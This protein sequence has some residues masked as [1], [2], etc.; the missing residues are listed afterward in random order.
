MSINSLSSK[1]TERIA[2]LDSLNPLS[3]S[4]N[5][6]AG[7]WID[8]RDFHDVLAAAQV[9]VISGGGTF[10]FKIQEANTAAGGSPA[11]ITGKAITQIGQTGSPAVG[12][13]N[14][15]VFI[16]L[17]ADELTEGFRWVRIVITT[18]TAASVCAAQLYGSSPR[19]GPASDYDAGS[20]HDFDDAFA[21]R[22]ISRDLAVQVPV[23]PVIP[24]LQTEPTLPPA[25]VVPAKT[26]TIQ[27][28]LEELEGPAEVKP[29]PYRATL[30]RRSRS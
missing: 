10:N 28:V 12:G 18:A 26:A 25:T 5:T 30:S 1:P 11:D 16:N 22:W 15:Q 7:A 20:V 19:H 6:Y 8:T 2:L 14:R 17:R 24:A 9:G 4:A 27:D 29:P 21:K 13:S 23:R 3:R